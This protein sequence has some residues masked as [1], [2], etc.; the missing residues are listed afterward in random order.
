MQIH[1]GFKKEKVLEAVF[2]KRVYEPQS[3]RRYPTQAVYGENCWHVVWTVDQQVSN[4]LQI[5]VDH[6]LIMSFGSRLK[7]RGKKR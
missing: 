3:K 2:F 6:S 7:M 5:C 1:V 4:Q